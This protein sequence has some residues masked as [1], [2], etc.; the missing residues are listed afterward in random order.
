MQT[1]GLPILL[2]VTFVL[3]SGCTKKDLIL[4]MG[5]GMLFDWRALLTI[6]I[7]MILRMQKQK[8]LERGKFLFPK[9]VTIYVHQKGKYLK[10]RPSIRLYNFP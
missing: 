10:I 9:D 2:V 6:S 8:K 5:E 3:L 1:K 4:D 7:V